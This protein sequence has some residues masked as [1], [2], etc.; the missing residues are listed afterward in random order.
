MSHGTGKPLPSVLPTAAPC[1]PTVCHGRSVTRWVAV[2]TGVLDVLRRA[3]PPL[4]AVKRMWS[5]AL[6][7]GTRP[8]A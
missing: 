2:A 8:V 6:S 7:A 1:V 5:R 4:T 3:R